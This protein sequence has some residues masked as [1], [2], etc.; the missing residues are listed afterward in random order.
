[1]FLAKTILKI[2]C[3]F[4]GEHP[5]RSVISIKLLLNMKCEQSSRS[6]VFYL[7][8]MN[9]IVFMILSMTNSLH[10]FFYK[11]HFYKQRQPEIGKKLSK[12]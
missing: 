3:K 12:S 7:F 4:T 10:A 9:G 11:H 1:M 8:I 5:R 2:C 6:K